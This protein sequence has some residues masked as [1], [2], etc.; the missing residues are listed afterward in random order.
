MKNFAFNVYNKNWF[1]AVWSLSQ[2]SVGI[3][4]G[5]GGENRSLF[6]D[7]GFTFYC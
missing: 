7:Y 6:A 2:N 5:G 3:G 1:V 4:D